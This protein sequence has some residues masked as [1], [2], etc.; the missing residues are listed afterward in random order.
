MR[1]S[2]FL[3]IAVPT[4]AR[5][6]NMVSL[7]VPEA[8]QSPSWRVSLSPSWD[9]SPG[10]LAGVTILV[11]NLKCSKVLGPFP[12]HAREQHFLSPSYPLNRKHRSDSHV[13]SPARP[14]RLTADS[15]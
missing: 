9:V 4:V 10:G 14:D 11:L 5:A 2:A 8:V 6:Q 3:A 13:T 7:Q 15:F 1:L 12:I